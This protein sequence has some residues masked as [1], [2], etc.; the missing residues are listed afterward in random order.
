MSN[1]AGPASLY[2]TMPLAE[3]MIGLYFAVGNANHLAP[4]AGSIRCFPPTRSPSR[5]GRRPILH[6]Q[7]IAA[8]LHADI[9][10]FP[11]LAEFIEQGQQGHRGAAI[12]ARPAG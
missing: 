5:S 10:H 1:H 11:V 3:G 2:A 6:Q 8:A 9:T 7:R 4:W 12:L